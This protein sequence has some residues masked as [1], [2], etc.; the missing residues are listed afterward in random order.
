MEHLKKRLEIIIDFD[1][2][3]ININWNED[4]IKNLERKYN[5]NCSID[6]ANKKRRILSTTTRRR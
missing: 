4:H 2:K 6:E 1:I 5:I 3:E